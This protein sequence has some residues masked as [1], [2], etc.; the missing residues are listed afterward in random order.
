MASQTYSIARDPDGTLVI[1]RLRLSTPNGGVSVGP[2]GGQFALSE[3]IAS[4]SF[5]NIQRIEAICI[6]T[7]TTA[8]TWNIRDF[9]GSAALIALLVQG[10]A[11]VNPG[12]RYIWE[13]PTPLQA[14]TVQNFS[15]QFHVQVVGTQ[16]G[17]WFFTANGY[18]T[19]VQQG[20]SI[21]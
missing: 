5:G 16:M 20:G 11:P 4:G 14:G 19:K 2:T 3:A 13:F 12:E 1:A 17:T 7:G 21:Y 15:S 6:A 9:S 18:E 8:G 10:K